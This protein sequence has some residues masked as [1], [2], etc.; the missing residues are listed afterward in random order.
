MDWGERRM[1]RWS[2]LRM[3]KHAQQR[4]KK[5]HLA[6]VLICSDWCWVCLWNNESLEKKKKNKKQK[7]KNKFGPLKLIW[8]KY[9]FIVQITYDVMQ[10][11]KR[12]RF[13]QIIFCSFCKESL[14]FIV[15]HIFMNCSA[16]EWRQR[17][18]TGSANSAHRLR[19]R[20]TF[21]FVTATEAVCGWY[22]RDPDWNA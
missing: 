3:A 10:D 22:L 20:S 18:S 9:N 16:A 1:Q 8:L 4:L 12:E 5:G 14:E 7:M 6:Y 17:G 21:V 11:N 19:P 13:Y 2:G 15:S